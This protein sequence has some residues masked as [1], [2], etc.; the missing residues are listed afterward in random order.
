MIKLEESQKE[1][2]KAKDN[3]SVWKERVWVEYCAEVNIVF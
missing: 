2:E 1:E 3:G